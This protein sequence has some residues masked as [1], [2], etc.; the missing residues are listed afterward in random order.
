LETGTALGFS[1][2]LEGKFPE[3]RSGPKYAASKGMRQLC[4]ALEQSS[5]LQ[6]ER[7]ER[8]FELYDGFLQFRVLSYP[9]LQGLQEP[10]S[11]GNVLC[12]LVRGCLG[13]GYVSRIH[14]SLSISA[15]IILPKGHSLLILLYGVEQGGVARRGT[16]PRQLGSKVDDKRQLSV[17]GCLPAELLIFLLGVDQERN[18]RIRILPCFE[19]SSVFVTR[20]AR[21]ILP[22]QHAGQAEV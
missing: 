19:K 1:L 22:D 14:G 16:Q 13:C 15:P 7:A 2:R 5:C 9:P 8:Q 17:H 6:S 11:F 4:K 10:M 21:F 3:R 18:L 20:L 12:R